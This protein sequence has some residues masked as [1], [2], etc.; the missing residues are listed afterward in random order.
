MTEKTMQYAKESLKTAFLRYG[1]NLTATQAEALARQA[2]ADIDW[3]DPA[4]MH[5]DLN[6]I[7]RIYLERQSQKIA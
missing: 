7:A 6:W 5:K 3:T 2:V 4:L 1:E